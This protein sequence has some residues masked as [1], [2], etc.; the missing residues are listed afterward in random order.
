MKIRVGPSIA[1]LLGGVLAFSIL[2][3]QE[4]KP[5]DALA[6]LVQV[7]AESDDPAFH[8]D[9]LKGMAEAL[10]GRRGVAMPEG[11]PKVA[12]KLRASPSAEVKALVGQLSTIFGDASALEAARKVLLDRSAR[13]EDRNKALASLLETKPA[14]LVPALQELLADPAVRAGAIRGLG[15]YDDPRTPALLIARYGELRPA[16]KLDVLNTLA[17]RETWAAE[18]LKAVESKAVPRT[19]LTAAVV[20]TLSDLKVEAIDKWLAANFGAIRSS[21]EDKLKEMVEIRAAVAAAKP[22]EVSASRG[23]AVYARVCQQCHTLFDEGGKVGPDLTGSGRADL[24]YIL[25]N[26]VD[27]NAVVGKDY[28]SWIIRLKDRRQ[29]AG[30]V[31]REDEHSVTLVTENETIIVP[32]KEILRMKQ[33]EVSMMPEGLLGG[34]P[35]QE[36]LD[37]IAYLRSPEQVPLPA[38]Q[39]ATD[40]ATPAATPPAAP[41]ATPAAP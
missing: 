20:R 6:P 28:L 19:D 9:I 40:P 18:L 27:P 10:K 2:H 17:S 33:S 15:L 12:E 31:Q 29:L 16:E 7:L 8:A 14:D 38:T 13:P 26:V 36:M 25:T 39:P 3:A 23:R 21:P 30:L 4:E 11:W 24:E 1:A 5:E 37:L 41:P 32:K 35:K 22:E 34:L